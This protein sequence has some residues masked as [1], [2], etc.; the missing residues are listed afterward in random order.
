M[1]LIHKDTAESLFGRDHFT[2]PDGSAQA[3]ANL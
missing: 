1:P 3:L 2:N